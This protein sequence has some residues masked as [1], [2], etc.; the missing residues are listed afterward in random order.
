[1]TQFAEIPV[2]I[3]VRLRGARVWVPA[4][5]LLSVLVGSERAA[6]W[7]EAAMWRCARWRMGSGRWQRFERPEVQ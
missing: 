5:L 6:R 7:A 3:Q 1:M 4:C 2:Q